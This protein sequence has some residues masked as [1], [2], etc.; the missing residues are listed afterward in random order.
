MIELD[1]QG[2]VN[3]GAEIVDLSDNSLLQ[4]ENF[5]TTAKMN[6]NWKEGKDY[7]NLKNSI[8]EAIN[9]II[10]TLKTKY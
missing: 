4:Q 3:L 6:G 8:Q 1:K 5:Q 2:Y 9:S 10:S 7:E